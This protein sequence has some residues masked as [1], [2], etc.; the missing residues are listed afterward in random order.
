MYFQILIKIGSWLLPLLQLFLP[1]LASVAQAAKPVVDIAVAD[2]F[3]GREG[4][5]EGREAVHSSPESMD[6]E[7]QAKL[8]KKSVEWCG[9][10]RE[11]VVIEL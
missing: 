9:F 7:V 11:D 6:Q 1:G 4:Y 8:W 2:E 5:F 10:M 3:A